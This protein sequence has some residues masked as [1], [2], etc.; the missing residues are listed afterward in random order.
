MTDRLF[1]QSLTQPTDRFF[2]LMAVGGQQAQALER[3]G[4]GRR[5]GESLAEICLR[6][7]QA[8]DAE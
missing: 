6:L 1:F 4:T 2:R 5:Q 8:S 7:R 3:Q